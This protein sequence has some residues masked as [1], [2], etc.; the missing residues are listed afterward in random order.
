M[1]KAGFC[2]RQRSEKGKGGEEE[3]RR[4]G[5]QSSKQVPASSALLIHTNTEHDALIHV[6]LRRGKTHESTCAGLTYVQQL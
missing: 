3:E 1:L 5:S 2:L 6:D 4:K